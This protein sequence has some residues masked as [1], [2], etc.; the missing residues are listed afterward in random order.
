MV[1]T[2]LQFSQLVIPDQGR[3][4]SLEQEAAFVSILP[5]PLSPHFYQESH[6]AS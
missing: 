2:Y 1:L 4:D 3:W 6:T 5:F